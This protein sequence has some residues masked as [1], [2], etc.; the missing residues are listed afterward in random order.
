[1]DAVDRQRLLEHF[2]WFLTSERRRRIEEVLEARTRHV[3]LVLENVFRAHNISAVL[4]SCD[5]F[6]IQD[7][8]IIDRHNDF[9]VA[10]DIALGAERWLTVRRYRETDPEAACLEA[11]R[12][13]GY[14]L[15]VTRHDANVQRLDE[16]D[17][18]HKTALILGN[19]HT[20]V[21]DR[22]SAVAD[23]V[24]CIP[25]CG[26][27]K[28]LNLSVAAAVCLYELTSR[29]R[30]SEVCWQLTEAERARL[31]FQWTRQSVRHAG[32]I[33]TRFHRLHCSADCGAS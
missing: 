20:G 21:S 27:V 14:R 28:S 13:E 33:E 18:S 1:M 22:L 4:R 12:N 31:R 8:H 3:V 11:L 19:E 16:V 29:L 24:V 26:F 32:D 7:V 25:T 6:G 2:Q 9:D 17:L 15:L 30:R 5:A 10:R 23:G